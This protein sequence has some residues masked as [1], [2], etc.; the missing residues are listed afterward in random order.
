[1]QQGSAFAT[2]AQS[3]CECACVTAKA[4]ERTSR[5]CNAAKQGV[6]FAAG[7]PNVGGMLLSPW[8]LSVVVSMLRKC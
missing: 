1:M 8:L 7:C 5:G 3:E 2:A 4:Q 6:L